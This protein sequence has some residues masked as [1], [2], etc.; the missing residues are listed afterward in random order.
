MDRLLH[1]RE[2]DALFLELCLR[3]AEHLHLEAELQIVAVEICPQDG[4][5]D[6][7]CKGLAIALREK[8]L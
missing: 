5:V 4:F 6:F 8:L 1:F 7:T 3:P 2:F